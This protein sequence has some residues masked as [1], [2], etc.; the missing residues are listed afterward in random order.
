MIFSSEASMHA[1]LVPI[2]YPCITEIFACRSLAVDTC[3]MSLEIRLS[4]ECFLTPFTTVC[5]TSLARIPKYD[6]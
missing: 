6:Y 3:D 2:T 1:E 4:F 5:T